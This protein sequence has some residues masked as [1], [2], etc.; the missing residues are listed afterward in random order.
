MLAARWH[1][2]GD[3]RVEEVETPQPGPGEV[4][5]EV[6]WCGI[7]GTDVE[8]YR[9][10]PLVIPTDVANLVTGRRAPLI[11]GHEFG[12][13]VRS[14]GSGVSGL[15]PGDPVAVEVC[16]SC[17]QCV[18]CREGRTALCSDWAAYGLQTDGGLAEAVVVRADQCLPRPTSIGDRKAALVEPTEVAVRAVRKLDIKRGDSA[19]VLGG[20]TIGLLSAQVLRAWGALPV[21]VITG[22]RTSADI[23]GDL[24]LEVIDSGLVGWEDAARDRTQGLGPHAV[25]EAQGRT[26]SLGS[27]VRLA[28]KGGR[29]VATGLLPGAHPVDIIDLA[30][31]EKR[32]M[33][34]IQHERDSDLRP[35]L[36]LVAS[37]AVRPEPLI[38]GEVPL[39]RVVS[40]GL[41]ALA[42]PDRR[43]V[44]LLVRTR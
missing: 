40:D 28:R 11:L 31:G 32:V 44:K 29:I 41:K 21:I 43:H 19:V 37:G 36:E 33:G 13:R 17:G 18:F 26:T 12:G 5:L 23:A 35:A 22:Q 1:A 25:V 4:L 30:V 24:G 34:S 9:E 6:G 10:G 3:V 20:G 38:T 27:A 15:A 7:C 42:A 39:D 2:R 8:E 16:L 14:L